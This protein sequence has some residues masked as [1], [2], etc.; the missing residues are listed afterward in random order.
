[1]KSRKK[2]LRCKISQHHFI[3]KINHF[4]AQNTTQMHIDDKLITTSHVS[5]IIQSFHGTQSCSKNNKMRTA[6]CSECK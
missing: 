1:M 4:D 5:D 3:Q 6:V 2:G